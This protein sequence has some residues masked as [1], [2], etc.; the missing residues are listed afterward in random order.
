MGG[1]GLS[2]NVV[3]DQTFNGVDLVG[4][5]L[6]IGNFI[7]TS[8]F[9]T[10]TFS[11]TTNTYAPYVILGDEASDPADSELVHGTP[12]QETPSCTPLASMP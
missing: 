8:S 2:E 9:G 11:S 10:P 4:R 3:L 5:P 1:N 12:Y 6:S 7:S